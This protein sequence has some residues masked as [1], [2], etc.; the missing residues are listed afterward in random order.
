MSRQRWVH[1]AIEDARAIEDAGGVKTKKQ[2]TL[3]Q[4]RKKQASSSA[5]GP[6]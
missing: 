3:R 1:L 5:S 4:A 6:A 2:A